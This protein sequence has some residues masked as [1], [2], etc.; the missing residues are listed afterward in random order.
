MWTNNT[1]NPPYFQFTMFADFGTSLRSICFCLCLLIY[2][3]I[4]VANSAIAMIVISQKSLH[5]PMYIFL[6]CLSLNSLYGSAAFFPRFLNDVLSDAHLISR[7][8]CFAQMYV[9][10]SYKGQELNI[11]TIMAYDR[12]VAVFQPLR[13]NS[14]MS[15]SVVRYLLLAAVLHPVFVFGF[16]FY[17]TAKLPL[18]ENKLKKMYCTIWSVVELS[19]VD[20]RTLENISQL[21]VALFIF[22][23]LGFVLYTYLRILLV[24][25]SRSSDFKKKT[26]QTCIPHIVTFV[27]Y[28]TAVFCEVTLSL[29]TI[30]K[31][32]MFVVAVLSLEFL[33]IPPVSNP[34]VYGLNLPQIRA[35][36]VRRVK[37]FKICFK[38]NRTQIDSAMT[39]SF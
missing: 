2:L 29:F 11:L 14:K 36:I 13:Y 27:N 30:E 23:P 19:C 39:S 10:H 5:R 24:C 15:L 7:A 33:L 20:T 3:I 35:V 22:L 34:L 9:I 32:N 17:L 28:C 6:C 8:S 4:I 26:L 18:C 12:Y 38:P 31:A 25:R 16:I 1:L 21:L 37:L